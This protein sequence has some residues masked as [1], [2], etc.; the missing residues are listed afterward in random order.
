MIYK[1][2]SQAGGAGEGFI[3][4]L[5]IMMVHA[6]RAL[7][8]TAN[9]CSKQ[10]LAKLYR[11]VY[12]QRNFKASGGQRLF[13]EIKKNEEYHAGLEAVVKMFTGPQKPTATRTLSISRVSAVIKA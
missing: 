8:D 4:W 9:W 11:V 12:D 13:D 1:K 3:V 10:A 2:L 5:R 6:V 7:A